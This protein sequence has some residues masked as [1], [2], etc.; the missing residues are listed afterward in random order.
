[1]QNYNIVAFLGLQ[2]PFCLLI[3]G[4]ANNLEENKKENDKVIHLI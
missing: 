1:M 4:G 3:W 2:S